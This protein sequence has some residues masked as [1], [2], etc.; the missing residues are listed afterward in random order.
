MTSLRKLQMNVRRAILE[1]DAVA[2]AAAV[3][4]DG[5]APAARLQ[6]H[7]NHVFATL[8]DA[9][10][11]T[12]PV[13]RRIVGERFFAALADRFIRDVPPRDP[14][15]ALWGAAF[16]RFVG[17]APG[18][19]G[20]PYLSD[21]ARL[22]WAMRVSRRA[23]PAVAIAPDAILAVPAADQPRVVLRLDSSLRILVS[24][25]PA[26]AIWQANQA[27]GEVP[28]VDLGRGGGALEIRRGGDGVAMAPIARVD[29]AFR[30]DLLRRRPLLRATAAALDVDPFFDLALAIRALFAGGYVVG[31][32]VLPQDHP[33]DKEHPSWT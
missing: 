9:L 29:A 19:A 31:L 28:T 24:R 25:W 3:M 8:T 27:P 2:I 15:L 16:P 6:V 23:A 14:R 33:N 26:L 13:V 32:S 5:M 22:E 4:G 10:A 11:V 17:A 21:V 18:C 12:Y 30:R 20:L 1:G 7:V